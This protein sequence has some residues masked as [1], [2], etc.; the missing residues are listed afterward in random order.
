MSAN[1]KGKY[2]IVTADDNLPGKVTLYEKAGRDCFTNRHWH[3]NLE[4]DY[5]VRGC[6]WTNMNGVDKDLYDGDYM[7]IN[8]E[9]VHQTCGKD[10]EDPVFSEKQM[11]SA[12]AGSSSTAR[13]RRSV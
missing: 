3:K 2:E 4:I 7:L 1:Y 6:M 13:E 10:P 5:I 12:L 8:S 9:A 11:N